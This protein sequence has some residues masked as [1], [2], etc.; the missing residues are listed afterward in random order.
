MPLVVFFGREEKEVAITRFAD[1][2]KKIEILP[3]E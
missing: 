3:K 2:C 1:H